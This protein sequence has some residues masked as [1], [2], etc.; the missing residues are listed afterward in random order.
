[1]IRARKSA[2]RFSSDRS[3]QPGPSRQVRYLLPGGR[4]IGSLTNGA[5]TP[6]QAS[7]WI[8]LEPGILPRRGRAVELDADHP[9]D[10]ELVSRVLAEDGQA[11]ETLVAR[12]RCVPR[13]LGRINQ[14]A[15]GPLGRE[16]LD[17]LTQDALAA[18]WTRLDDYSGRASLETWAYGFCVNVFMN[19]WRRSR[20]HRARDVAVESELPVS[21]G[22]R[23]FLSEYEELHRGLAQLE[24]VDTRVIRLKYFEDMTFEEIG[25]RLHIP[26][27]KA[28]TRFYRGMK[29]LQSLL[30]PWQEGKS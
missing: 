17:D 20:K 3:V 16:D 24:E 11:I 29:R 18:L 30:R 7:T 25:T 12:L 23:P 14:R 22:E 6:V 9:S 27:R 8:T 26:P 1:M 5:L 2:C 10:R 13:I 28:K 15:G 19:G 4:R 21:A